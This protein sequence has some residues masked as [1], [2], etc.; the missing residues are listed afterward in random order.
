MAIAHFAVGAATTTLLIAFVIP[1]IDY[2]RTLILIG[3]G[4]ALLPDIHW[5]TPI[6]A[7]E[8][9]RFHDGS[10][11]IDLFWFHRFM[12]QVDPMN[13]RAIAAVC[14]ALLCIA[15]VIADWQSYRVPE[16]DDTTIESYTP[17][18]SVAEQK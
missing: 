11:W 17:D 1:T 2:Q 18:V 13:D 15:T 7:T 16:S 14:L 3:G 9:H 10:P 12:D 6:A 8:I 5:V 4:W